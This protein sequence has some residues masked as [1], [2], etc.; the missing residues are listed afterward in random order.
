MYSMLSAIRRL[1]GIILLSFIVSA[2]SAQPMV[3]GTPD[4][5]PYKIL[6]SG[7]QITI[8]ATS[9]IKQ[10]MLWTTTGNRLIE[11]RAINNSNYTFTLPLN[12]KAYYLMIGLH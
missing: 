5:K 3:G 6:S 8:K 10:V 11:E 9:N 2:L 7:K 4:P 12:H 1:P